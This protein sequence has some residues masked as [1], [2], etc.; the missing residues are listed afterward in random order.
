VANA[1]RF[2]QFGAGVNEC[3]DRGVEFEGACRVAQS[4][5][6]ALERG[7]GQGEHG[8]AEVDPG[9]CDAQDERGI[10][11]RTGPAFPE[12]EVEMGFVGRLVFGEAQVVGD[13][14]RLPPMRG[15]ARSPSATRC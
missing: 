13:P 14:N 3:R 2:A 11:P 5:P 7:A 4:G 15:S 1:G 8:G 10:A 12:G 9:G 6:V